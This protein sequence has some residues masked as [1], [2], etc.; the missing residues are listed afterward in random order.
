MA[1]AILLLLALESTIGA[2]MANKP[3]RR[4]KHKRNEPFEMH[5]VEIDHQNRNQALT[6]INN[7]R[8]AAGVGPLRFNSILEET[9]KWMARC[10]QPG[11]TSHHCG[12]KKDVEHAQEAG[13][14]SGGGILGGVIAATSDP[15]QALADFEAGQHSSFHW[16]DVRDSRYCE[17]GWASAKQWSIYMLGCRH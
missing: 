8:N 17:V 12:S 13:Y 7:V 3:D 9:A 1:R 5:V 11:N 15:K 16:E 10:S 2:R 14:L 4:P 6:A